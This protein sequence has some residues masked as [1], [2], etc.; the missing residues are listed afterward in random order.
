MIDLQSEELL[1]VFEVTRRLPN[2]PHIATVHRWITRGLRGVKLEATRIGGRV[3]T[4]VEALQ[5][6][7]DALTSSGRDRES[8]ARQQKP[9]LEEELNRIGI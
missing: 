6:F 7:A 2:R 4:S 1:S 9:N 3:F 8:R 5:R